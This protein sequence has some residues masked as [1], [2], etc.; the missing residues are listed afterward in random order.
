VN[1]AIMRAFVKLRQVLASHRERARKIEEHDEQIAV[2]FETV[3][4]LRCRRIRRR[5]TRSGTSPRK[6]ECK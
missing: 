5:R 3:Q 4:N 2:L 6:I 1:I